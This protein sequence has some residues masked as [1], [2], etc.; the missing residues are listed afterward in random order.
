MKTM[1]KSVFLTLIAIPA[2]ADEARIDAVT[3]QSNGDNWRFSVALTHPDTGWAHYAD[4]W[5]ILDA[6]GR[7]LGMRPLMHPHVN[8]QPF[9]RSLAGVTIPAGTI[10]VFIQARCIVDGWGEALFEVILEPVN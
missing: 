5:R 4:G 1:L 10:S 9:S 6:N 2:L 8:E 7:E 3:A